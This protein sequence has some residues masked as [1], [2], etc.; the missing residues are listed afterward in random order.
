MFHIR[1]H[2]VIMCLSY[3]KLLSFYELSCRSTAEHPCASHH[4]KLNGN[5][6]NVHKLP[7]EVIV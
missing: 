4:T 1:A 5:I 2:L 7:E 6:Q 3:I